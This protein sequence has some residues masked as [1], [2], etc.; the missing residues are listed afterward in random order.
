[1]RRG[2]YEFNMLLSEFLEGM[3]VDVEKD[4]GIAVFS[5]WERCDLIIER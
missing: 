4:G 5:E 3:L 1:M 2:I